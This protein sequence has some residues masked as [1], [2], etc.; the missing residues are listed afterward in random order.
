MRCREVAEEEA[1]SAG[2]AVTGKA[3]VEARA[4]EPAEDVTARAAAGGRVED[5]GRAG[6]AAANRVEAEV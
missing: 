2:E 1:E 4:P 6:P 5:R 3:V